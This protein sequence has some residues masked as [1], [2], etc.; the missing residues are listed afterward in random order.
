MCVHGFT[1]T[2]RT[3]EL[4]LDRLDLHHEVLAPTLPGHA[5]G[6]PLEGA[7]SDDVLADA[8]ESAMDDAGF[9]TAHLVGN[10][11]G[12]YLA[13]RLAARGRARSVVAFAPE[14]IKLDG[15]GHC[16]QLDIP[17]ETGELILGFTAR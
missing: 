5:G 12:G 11:L 13:L 10:S 16:P 15:I 7:I 8:L 14:W 4:V 3:W 2:W 17:L 1:D 6:P 9:Q